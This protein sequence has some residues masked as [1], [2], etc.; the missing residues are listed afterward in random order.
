[1]DLVV[2]L[3]LLVIISWRTQRACWLTDGTDGRANMRSRCVGQVW[4]LGSVL[5]NYLGG[6]YCAYF[7]LTIY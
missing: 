5:L 7:N 4:N 1:M 2:I 3:H 6:L